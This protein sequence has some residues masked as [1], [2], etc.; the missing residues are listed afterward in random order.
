MKFED[1][2]HELLKEN[3]TVII[4]GFGAFITKYQPAKIT[5]NKIIPPS[6]IIEFNPQIRNNDGLLVGY[7]A[8]KEKI[9]HFDALRSIEKER[10]NIIFLLDKGEEVNLEGT[11]ILYSSERKE[12]QFRPVH[13]ETLLL[14]SFGLEPV[15]LTEEEI[16]DPQPEEITGTEEINEPETKDAEVEEIPEETVP[17]DESREIESDNIPEETSEVIENEDLQEEATIIAGSKETTQEET[18]EE[19]QVPEET[20]NKETEIEDESQPEAEPVEETIVYDK[21]SVEPEKAEHEPVAE[22]EP[23]FIPSN[24]PKEKKKRS[25]FWYLLVLVPIIVAGFFIFNNQKKESNPPIKNETVVP[26]QKT[27]VNQKEEMMADTVQNEMAVEQAQDS[28]KV[29][30][31][32][33][34]N[35]EVTPSDSL[36][37]YLVGGGFK[38]QENAETYLNELKEKGL[39]PFFM[40]K[41]GNFYLVGL[42]AFK[43]EAEA[44]NAKREYTE[45]HP[46][47]GA[48][49]LEE[50]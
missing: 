43:T 28:A 18:P 25:G 44:V 17:I 29:M 40:G 30:E 26:E 10:E 48:W 20:Q 13:D 32:A 33:A 1:Y 47:S 42:G 15:S 5:E 36:K 45:N 19:E 9:S 31:T 27:P 16:E 22:K 8:G 7:I 41:R 50:K 23:V 21:P 34:Q 38:E 12:I 2:I 49:I 3:E 4:P 46:G 37:F 39:E 6:I 35:N 14:D 24:E 11:G